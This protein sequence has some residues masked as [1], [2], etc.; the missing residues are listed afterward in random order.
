MSDQ[1][2]M[3]RNG[4]HT[5]TTNNALHDHTPSL[6]RDHQIDCGTALHTH[7]QTT[8][9]HIHRRKS[10]SETSQRW[11]QD[12][13][14]NTQPYTSTLTVHAL[15]VHIPKKTSQR[16]QQG[17]Q[18]PVC[19]LHTHVDG[20]NSAADGPTCKPD[21]A[22]DRKTC[23]AT[24]ATA[25]VCTPDNCTTASC[26]ANLSFPFTHHKAPFPRSIH[27]LW[28]SHA[29]PTPDKLQHAVQ[30]KSHAWQQTSG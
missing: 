4:T 19:S 20:P 23:Y 8:H 28:K 25:A 22:T 14:A 12:A 13:G 16:W 29:E 10:N 2:A 1:H 5:N 7:I 17:A 18:Q 26:P 3:C 21:S 6:P 9:T 24:A 30:G 15:T 11:H 27:E